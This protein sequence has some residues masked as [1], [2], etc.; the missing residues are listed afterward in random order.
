MTL[1]QK[2]LFDYFKEYCFEL[3]GKALVKLSG[4]SSYT[5]ESDRNLDSLL[6]ILASESSLKTIS[7]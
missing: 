1:L 7:N 6:Q 4:T 3:C 2:T 5:H